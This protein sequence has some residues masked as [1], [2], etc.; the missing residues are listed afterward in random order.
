MD[1]I[2]KALQDLADAIDNQDAVESVRIT[3]T[4]KKPKPSKATPKANN[5]FKAGMGRK[6]LPRVWGTL[7]ISQTKEDFKCL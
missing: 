6:P 3:I 1:E 4:L 2:K 5:A 7:I